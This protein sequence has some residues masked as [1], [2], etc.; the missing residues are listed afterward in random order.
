MF[1]YSVSLVVTN[2]LSD[3]CYYNKGSVNN[4]QE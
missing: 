3:R 1:C 2:T 4:H